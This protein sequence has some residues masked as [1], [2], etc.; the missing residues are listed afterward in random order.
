M[1][2]ELK[3]TDI[4]DKCVYCMR[5]TSFGSGLWVNRIP[6]DAD[7][8][9]ED[10]EGNI[11]FADGQYRDGY[12]CIECQAMECYYCGELTAEYYLH[13]N[14]VF[15][16]DCYEQAEINKKEPSDKAIKEQD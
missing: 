9:T 15:C 1:A 10:K 4:G 14:S 6:A 11:I 16:E 5:N 13:D 8:E 7:C 3:T 2:N 12:M